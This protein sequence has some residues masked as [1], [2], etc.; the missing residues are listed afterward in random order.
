MTLL[1]LGV[2][3]R[4]APVALREQ[5]AFSP[6]QIDR[7]LKS[8]HRC[9]GVEEAVIVSTCNRTELY[10]QLAVE[11]EQGIDL[12]QWL[13]GFHQIS[14]A[15]LHPSLYIYRDDEAIRHLMRVAAGLDSLVLGE[16]QILGQV[17]Q[18]YELARQ[19]GATTQIL[20]R[21]FQRT[22]A[23]AK[24]V[25]TETGIGASAVSVAFAAVSLAKQIFGDLDGTR[26]LLVGAGE[27]IELVGRHL[28]DQR[29]ARIAVANR[30]VQRAALLAE[31]IDAEAITLAE[32]PE[33]LAHADIVISSTASPLP[34][35]GK[36]MVETALRARRHKPMF[37]VDLAV[38][39]DIEAQVAELADAYLYSV[40]DLQG[41]VEQN[42]ASRQ[43]AAEEAEQIVASETEAFTGWLKSLQGVETIREYRRFAECTRD[44]LVDKALSDIANGL[45]AEQVIRQLGHQLTN[46]LIHHPTQALNRAARSGD[47]QQL[48]RVRRALGIEL[49]V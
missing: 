16:P 28:R 4:T 29:V 35:L 25:R 42:Q 8:L 3:H 2:S 6:E 32:I 34:I 48:E 38:P 18:S 37:L 11:P 41:L 33:A 19:L 27:T 23:V 10:C 12:G 13:A 39:R 9:P 7:A 44:Q 47:P 40:D 26:V 17:K 22:F 30:T 45:D 46:K 24:R 5:I 14:H 36:G 49:S 21:L 15:D 43:L 1:A 31:L 20:E